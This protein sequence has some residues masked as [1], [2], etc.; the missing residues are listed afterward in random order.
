ME[1]EEKWI[2]PTMRD[3]ERQDCLLAAGVKDVNPVRR[4]CR[5]PEMY[6]RLRPQSGEGVDELDLERNPETECEGSASMQSS[7][8]SCLSPSAVLSTLSLSSSSL[9]PS[10]IPAFTPVPNMDTVLVNER[11]VLDVYRRGGTVMPP[12]WECAPEQMKRV[13]YVRLGSE[14]EEA[15]E[16]A[17]GVLPHLTQLRSLAIRGIHTNTQI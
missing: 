15:L 12:L 16:D 10:F 5:E 13:E 8:S 11:L 14:D 6:Q 9:Q 2:Q 1:R 17:L 7:S 4:H 3:K